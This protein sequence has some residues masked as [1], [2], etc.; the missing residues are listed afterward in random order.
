MY[1]LEHALCVCAHVCTRRIH[2]LR[3]LLSVPTEVAERQ[4]QCPGLT[5]KRFAANE[6]I[7][8]QKRAGTW[9]MMRRRR[10]VRRKMKRDGGAEQGL[11]CSESSLAVKY[12]DRGI[13]TLSGTS[14]R[15]L[16]AVAW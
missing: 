5:P 11:D 14:S 15:P 13:S 16:D 4:Q 7:H 2:V 8:Q 3:S 12:D 9:G 6:L 1:V 10:R